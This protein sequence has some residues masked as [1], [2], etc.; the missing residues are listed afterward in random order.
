MTLLA[1]AL[2]LCTVGASTTAPTGS[3][4]TTST[5]TNSAVI[6]FVPDDARAPMFVAVFVES[7][8]ERSLTW[9]LS[10]H[11]D[12]LASGESIERGDGGGPM[13]LPR[14]PHGT[15]LTQ[16]RGGTRM[17]IADAGAWQAQIAG[18]HPTNPPCAHC[19]LQLSFYADVPDGVAVLEGDAVSVRGRAL[20]LQHLDVARSWA[21]VV[22]EPSTR[23]NITVDEITPLSTQAAC[24]QVLP[25]A[26]SMPTASTQLLARLPQCDAVQGRQ[27]IVQALTGVRMGPQRDTRLRGVLITPGTGKRTTQRR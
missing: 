12:T 7:G 8:A 17:R 20:L 11:D 5:A 26:I 9:T 1:A 14:A 24:G 3:T 19:A 25:T 10:G 23:A 22:D 18:A 27:A 4:D 15:V 16:N 6:V 21:V 2:L 13:L